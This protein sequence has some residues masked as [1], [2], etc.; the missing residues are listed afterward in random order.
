MISELK[1]FITVVELKN[2]TKAA[3]VLN[4]SQP[5]VSIHIKNLEA[6]FEVKLINRSVKQ[7]KI[8]ITDEGYR[9]YARAKEILA[10]IDTT[11]HELKTEISSLRGS[12]KIG[13]S[14]TIGEY[15]LPQFIAYFT[16]KYPEIDIKVLMN[17]TAAVCKGIK[18]LS[19]DIGFIEGPPAFGNLNQHCF[20]TDEMVLAYSSLLTG[21]STINS[22]ANQ[23]WISREDGSGTKEYLNMFLSQHHIIPKKLMILGS[24]YAI[25]EA[26]KNNLGITI[27]SKLVVND[28]AKN[29]ELNLFT[30]DDHF[31]RNFSYLTPKNV[32][33]NEV[34]KVFLHELDLFYKKEKS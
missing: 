24:N 4:L 6:Q 11:K 17:N 8:I 5:S 19:Y 32:T 1:T 20:Y 16:N 2:F 22:F 14:F 3:E 27:I 28:P 26:I 7:K 15:L 12:L 29:G 33:L 25:K 30:L 31:T 18:E 23:C 21:V 34:T 9:L 13:S 10:L